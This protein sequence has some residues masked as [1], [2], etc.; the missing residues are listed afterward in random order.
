MTAPRQGT[1]HRVSLSQ[2]LAEI[3]ISRG[4]DKN[5]FAGLRREQPVNSEIHSVTSL[6]LKYEQNWSYKNFA[7]CRSDGL[8]Y[9][10]KSGYIWLILGI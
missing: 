4:V 5:I 7:I 9:N 10:E 6:F 2:T 8:W 1:S 3:M